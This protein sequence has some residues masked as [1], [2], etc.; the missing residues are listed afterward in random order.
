MKLFYEL[1][2]KL[3]DISLL[4]PDFS[5]SS[6][7]PY[8]QSLA[9]THTIREILKEIHVN[10]DLV[11]EIS[12]QSYA[13]QNSFD[14]LI[15]YHDQKLNWRLRLHIWWPSNNIHED[16]DIHNHV[17][18][19]TSAIITGS[20]QNEIFKLSELGKKYYHYHY[21]IDDISCLARL[22]FIGERQLTL[23]QTHNFNQGDVYS[24]VKSVLH[25]V[26][27]QPNILAVSLVVQQ[28]RN[29]FS[30]VYKKEYVPSSS[31]IGKHGFVFNEELLNKKLEKLFYLLK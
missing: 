20:I 31:S 26:T 21:E 18:D 5:A 3:T 6:F 13:H 30:D 10:S 12:A 11:G 14:K 22:D 24:Q 23:S 16:T 27:V 28:I 19:Y 4:N 1:I 25:K 7:V 17:W 8:L 2:G 9:K 29:G 15:L